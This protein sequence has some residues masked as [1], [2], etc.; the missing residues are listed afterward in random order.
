MGLLQIGH[1]KSIKLTAL[2]WLGVCQL[3]EPRKNSFSPILVNFS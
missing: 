2:A 1:L 3:I